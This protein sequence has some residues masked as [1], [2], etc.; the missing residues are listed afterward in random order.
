MPARWSPGSRAEHLRRTVR[1]MARDSAR[2]SRLI[3]AQYL[4]LAL[5]VGVLLV[6]GPERRL[7]P[8]REMW[9]LVAIYVAGG[10]SLLWKR[11]RR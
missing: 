9:W 3:G 10:L 1:R 4:F 7:H 11:R 5:L 8:P 6:T 2:Q